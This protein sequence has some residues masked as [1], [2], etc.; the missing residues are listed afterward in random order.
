[1]V[2]RWMTA[3]CLCVLGCGSELRTVPLGARSG[4]ISSLLVDYPPPPA[5]VEELDADPG[6]PCAWL[7]GH[8][9]PSGA[10]WEWHPG[11]WVVPPTGCHYAPSQIVW[12]PSPEGAK[13]HHVAGGWF[14]DAASARACAEPRSCKK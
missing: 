8:W 14:P 10:T 1:M 11:G 13:R 9:E 12:R 6:E 7:D 2:Q 4:Q 3:T 5:Q